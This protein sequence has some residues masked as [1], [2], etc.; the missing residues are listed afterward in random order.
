MIF[1]M[2]VKDRSGHSAY[3]WQTELLFWPPVGCAVQVVGMGWLERD[4]VC[5]RQGRRWLPR[6]EQRDR[7]QREGI[8]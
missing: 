1:W 2:A 3:P 7:V 4:Y 8:Y 5:D 6:W